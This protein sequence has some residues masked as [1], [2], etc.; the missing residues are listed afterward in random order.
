MTSEVGWPILLSNHTWYRS[1]V[2]TKTLFLSLASWSSEAHRNPTY[3]TSYHLLLFWLEVTFARD[4][5]LDSSTLLTLKSNTPSL[6]QPVS[7]QSVL[8]M[9][10]SRNVSTQS[11][12]YTFPPPPTPPLI[13]LSSTG[14]FSISRLGFSSSSF[15][16]V[17]G[18]L[19]TWSTNAPFVSSSSSF[20]PPFASL[21]SATTYYHPCFLWYHDKVSSLA[22]FCLNLILVPC[23]FFHRT[24]EW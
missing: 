7:S 4:L 18:G 13:F 10:G 24:S 16:G 9:L 11:I 2:L 19:S 3:E 12:S 14:F 23:H 20:F 1:L 17:R 8:M 15:H 22:W 6:P 5:W 21:S